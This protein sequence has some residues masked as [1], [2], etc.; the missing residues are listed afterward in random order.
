MEK[1][2]ILIVEDEPVSAVL[3]EENI[4]ALGYEVQATV[5][6]GIEA[7]S[8]IE[9]EVPAVVLMDIML[10]GSMDGIE[11]AE[12]IIARFD[13]PVIYL[14]AFDEEELFKRAKETGPFGYIIKPVETR[15]LH[16]AIEMAVYQHHTEI[17]LKKRL[18]ELERLN[19]LMVG[20]E[21]KMNNMKKQIKELED[22]MRE[23]EK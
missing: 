6:S 4:K 11:A 21:L 14:T 9:K 18:D 22:R 13:V 23:L 7:I 16:R 1:K 3:I 17:E 12:I 10:E 15:D 19:K 8:E 2:K 20:R 5:K